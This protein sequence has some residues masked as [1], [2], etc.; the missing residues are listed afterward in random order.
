MR[1][2]S[3]RDIAITMA[4]MTPKPNISSL[5]ILAVWSRKRFEMESSER[6]LIG[7]QEGRTCL[8]RY[9]KGFGCAFA[10]VWCGR[11]RERSKVQ[12]GRMIKCD[13]GRAGRVKG[14]A[15]VQ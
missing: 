11:M 7:W 13:R 15:I 4:K 14:W 1:K 8:R 6:R 9:R 5:A 2:T 12:G 3:P 10:E